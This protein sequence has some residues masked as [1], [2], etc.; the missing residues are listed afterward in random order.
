MIARQHEPDVHA[1]R[2]LLRRSESAPA[3]Q[4]E[5]GGRVAA[6]VAPATRPDVLETLTIDTGWHRRRARSRQQR[7]GEPHRGVEVEFMCARRLVAAVAECSRAQL[8]PALFTSRSSRRGHGRPRA[9]HGGRAHRHPSGP[10]PGGAAELAGQRAQRGP[11]AA[12]RAPD[13]RPARRESRRAVYSP[14]PLEAPV[15]TATN[16]S[17]LAK[18][19]EGYPAR[20]G[21]RSRPP[22]SARRATASAAAIPR[23]AGTRRP[24]RRRVAARGSRAARSV[25]ENGRSWPPRAP[26]G[27]LRSPT[28]WS[29]SRRTA[30]GPRRRRPRRSPATRRLRDIAL[31]VPWPSPA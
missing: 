25:T 28:V 3:G 9:Q 10:L 11:R 18:R 24:R 23:R 27:E 6:R 12:P 5:L 17:G 21:S 16:G 26:R 19:P 4:R 20:A 7:L 14:M 2:A 22:R 29:R 15:T 8:A 31:L 1:V 13:G 30:R